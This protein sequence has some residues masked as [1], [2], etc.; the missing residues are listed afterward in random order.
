MYKIEMLKCILESG[1]KLHISL[2]L[3]NNGKIIYNLKLHNVQ[4]GKD[5]LLNHL[6]IKVWPIASVIQR[7]SR[8]IK[9][10]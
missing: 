1:D 5:A 8:I 2:T 10:F 9:R 6:K 7:L 3:T 4:K